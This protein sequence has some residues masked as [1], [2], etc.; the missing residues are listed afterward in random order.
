MPFSSKMHVFASVGDLS[1]EEEGT[2]ERSFNA[3]LR[4][5]SKMLDIGRQL[6]G[7]GAATLQ[8]Q[9]LNLSQSVAENK[10]KLADGNGGGNNG[11]NINNGGGGDGGDD[12]D[13]Y[14]YFDDDEE[15]GDDN[16]FTK[17]AAIPEL[18]DRATIECILQEWHKTIYSL[19]SGIRMAVEMGLVSSAQ[20]VRF[21]GM[22]ARPNL[23]RAVTRNTPAS[24]SR[25][26]VGRMM[27]DPSILVK[28]AYEQTLAVGL[29]LYYEAQQRGDKFKDELDLVAVNLAGVMISN[30]AMVWLTCPN[31]SFGAPTKFSWQR[32]LNNLPSNAFDR[33]GPLR[34]YTYVTRA[35]GFIYKAAQLSAIGVAVG[36]VSG[37][38]SHLLVNMRKKANPYFRPALATPDASHQ[39]AGYGAYCGITGNLRYQLM[40]GLDRYMLNTFSSLPLTLGVTALARF[41]GQELGEQTRLHWLGLPKDTKKRTTTRTVSVKKTVK[42]VRKV[43][44]PSSTV[45]AATTSSDAE[46]TTP[47]AAEDGFSVSASV[48]RRTH[49]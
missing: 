14:D 17:R 13:D 11:K 43:S 10:A 36:G 45:A 30:A 21:L 2:N 35:A 27:G 8:K 33:S 49:H 31:R 12:D 15:E 23:I 19:P 16:L 3:S 38:V 40:N 29:T 20:L 41:G 5:P 9:D 34:E 37:G 24:F 6:S 42:R 18:F 46:T 4:V 25:G 32:S 44:K 1:R 47:V 48:G 7:G 28:M 39:A 22:D 26:F